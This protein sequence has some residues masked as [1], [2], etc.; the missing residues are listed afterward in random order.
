[1][2]F[3]LPCER[4]GVVGVLLFGPEEDADEI[5]DDW[6]QEVEVG[7]ATGG[8]LMVDMMDGQW[9]GHVGRVPPDGRV[10]AG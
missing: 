4:S 9:R 1:M 10:E 8:L 6:R 2:S 7:V 3:S 5:S